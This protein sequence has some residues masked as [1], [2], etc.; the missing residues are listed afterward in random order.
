MQRQLV[1]WAAIG[2]IALLAY[3]TLRVAVTHGVDVL[4]V[5][6]LVVLA[7]LGIGVIGALGSDD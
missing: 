1:R 3:L 4:V 2:V 5:V 6:S 7:I